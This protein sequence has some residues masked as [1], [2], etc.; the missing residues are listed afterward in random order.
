ML[1]LPC[2]RTYSTVA[3]PVRRQRDGGWTCFKNHRHHMGYPRFLAKG[4]PIGSGATEVARMP[5]VQQRSYASGMHWKTK[6][7]NIVLIL[8][9]LT[10]TAGRWTQFWQKIDQFGAEYGC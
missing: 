5:L 3:E 1:Q 4:L 2:G 7:A 6:G 8:R 10:Q 9:A